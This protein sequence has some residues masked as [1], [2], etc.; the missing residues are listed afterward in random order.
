MNHKIN[1]NNRHNCNWC[2]GSGDRSGM[3]N[4]SSVFSWLFPTHLFVEVH[5]EMTST[6]RCESIWLAM[7]LICVFFFRTWDF[8]DCFFFSLALSLSA[9]ECSVPCCLAT[10]FSQFQ[11]TLG[12]KQIT[13]LILN[14]YEQLNGTGL[15]GAGEKRGDHS[16]DAAGVNGW[17]GRVSILETGSKINCVCL[18][19]RGALGPLKLWLHQNQKHNPESTQHSGLFGPNLSRSTLVNDSH[20]LALWLFFYKIA[21]LGEISVVLRML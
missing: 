9:R 21:Y 15:P 10:C 18:G 13:D 5:T 3:Q 12:L 1:N 8:M 7:F 2:S 6:R 14:N 17:V 11:H 20:S 4:K 19:M 16:R